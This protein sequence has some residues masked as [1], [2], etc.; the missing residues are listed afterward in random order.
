MTEATHPKTLRELLHEIDGDYGISLSGDDRILAVIAQLGEVVPLMYISKGQFDKLGEDQH[1]SAGQYLPVRLTPAGN[2]TFPL[3]A[4]TQV[5][6]PLEVTDGMVQAYLKANDKYWR[7]TDKLPTPPDKWR[8][9]TP[10][11]ATRAGLIA[12]LAAQRDEKE[13]DHD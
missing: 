7:D 12:A 9:G 5:L 8:T 4:G 13:Q 6:E 10:Y 2:F 11:G 3:F 1:E